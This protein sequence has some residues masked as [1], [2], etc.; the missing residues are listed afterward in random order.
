MKRKLLIL[1]L[2][3]VFAAIAAVITVG[4]LN[5]KT[6]TPESLNIDVSEGTETPESL[7]IDVS[8]GT[9]TPE[10]LLNID[11]SEVSDIKLKSG[12]TC[13]SY[14]ISSE[15]AIGEIVEMLNKI[16]VPERVK[17]E[18]EYIG[19]GYYLD[20]N[21]ET[22]IEVDLRNPRCVRTGGLY[23]WFEDEEELKDLYKYI[24]N[25][26]AEE[27]FAALTEGVDASEISKVELIESDPRGSYIISSEEDIQKL[28][29]VVNGI[30]QL[31][32]EPGGERDTE[33][34]K[35]YTLYFYLKDGICNYYDFSFYFGED[36]CYLHFGDTFFRYKNG[37][38][39]EELQE[40]FSSYCVS[41][42]NEGAF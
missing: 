42:T 27:N 34:E 1:C 8:E 41:E 38:E 10:R 7:N 16:T 35:G 12:Y 9:E 37:D 24:R 30:K 5:E 13:R 40:I 26:L 14:A 23:Y 22:T 25:Y 21:G 17:D 32:Q 29:D 2:V 20:L 15:K 33:T 6:E 31:E 4:A 18:Y 11:V 39:I 36:A 3:V 28:A 19:A